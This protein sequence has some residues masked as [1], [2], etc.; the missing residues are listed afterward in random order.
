HHHASRVLWVICGSLRIDWCKR[1]GRQLQVLLLI[2][3]TLNRVRPIFAKCR[4]KWLP[5]HSVEESFHLQLSFGTV[6]YPDSAFW[7]DME[8]CF[9]GRIQA[10]RTGQNMAATDAKR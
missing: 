2:A 1:L 5:R 10:S 8:F 7:V 4:S 9:S 6:L 3:G